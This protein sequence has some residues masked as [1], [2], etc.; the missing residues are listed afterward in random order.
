MHNPTNRSSLLFDSCFDTHVF[1]CPACN[2]SLEKKGERI[3]CTNK[4][5][6]KLQRGTFVVDEST[7]VPIRKDYTND[8]KSLFKQ[9]LK[10]Q[11][12]ALVQIVSPVYF[13]PYVKKS[14]VTRANSG[15]TLDLGC[16][17][18]K[19]PGSL[20]I[21]IFHYTG[22]DVVCDIDHLPI[23][24]NSIDTVLI[25]AVLEHVPDD[26]AVIHEIFRVLKKNGEVFC[27]YPFM[28]GYH[29]SPHDYTRRTEAGLRYIFKDFSEVKVISSGGPTSGLLWI[30]QEWV[31]IACSFGS[32]R[33]YYCILYA[34]MLVT[35]PFKFLD[36]F[37][38]R[39]PMASQIS[40]GFIVI[41]R[42]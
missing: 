12:A 5:I 17:P 27:F 29:A 19:T 14:C 35:F 21:D 20:G 8:L 10:N 4:H 39:H 25:R 23:K 26:R 32:T 38:L 6:F 9:R 37:L 30:L 36:I 3:F 11:Y 18:N 16:G 34:V 7:A 13:E 1:I 33:L 28:Q 2:L 15:L 31:A 24:A 40:S 41:A 22:V 42:K